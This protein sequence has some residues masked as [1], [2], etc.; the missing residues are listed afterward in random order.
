MDKSNYNQSKS[1]FFR[2]T[3][4][5]NKKPIIAKLTATKKR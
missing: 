5:I 1:D 2:I 3:L 4:Y